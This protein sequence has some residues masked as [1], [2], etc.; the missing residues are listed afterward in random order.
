M[1]DR[2]GFYQPPTFA[3]YSRL[4]SIERKTNKKKKQEKMRGQSSRSLY[5]CRCAGK[6]E[7]RKK[8]AQP[9]AKY[10]LVTK[11]QKP[12]DNE[13][14]SGHMNLKKISTKGTNDQHPIAPA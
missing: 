3:P 6:V 7:K 10:S 14:F 11:G 8:R 4:V 13:T 5:S 1:F 9:C 12:A 2:H